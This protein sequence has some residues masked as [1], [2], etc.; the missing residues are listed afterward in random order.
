MK[1]LTRLLARL[2]PSRWR[3]R[4][5]DEFDAL[6]ED[7]PPKPRD[8]FDILWGAFKMQ[9]STWTFASITLA[10]AVT[11]L[12]A[13]FTIS[14][15]LPPTYR[16]HASLRVAPERI[17][18]DLDSMFRD[19]CTSLGGGT[20]SCAVDETPALQRTMSESVMKLTQNVLSS[21]SL[22]AIIQRNNLYPQERARKSFDELAGNMRKNIV[23]TPFPAEYPPN[24]RPAIVVFFNYPDARVAQQVTKELMWRL[25]EGNVRQ[26]ANDDLPRAFAARRSHPQ[27]DGWLNSHFEMRLEMLAFP[28]LPARPDGPNRA[29]IAGAGLFA[30]LLTG[31]AL[32]IVIRSRRHIAV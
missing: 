28:S 23:V 18:V 25:I 8:A 29:T 1:R 7:A 12:L 19:G 32:A 6:L 26:N 15:S 24:R 22:T 11:G 27:G 17:V 20:W 10:C 13:S 14:L 4:Y 3:Q 21:N 30:G 31:L 5:G 9:M 2:Y 16:S